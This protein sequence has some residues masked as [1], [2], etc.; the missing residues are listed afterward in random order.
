MLYSY[1]SL[2]FF[3]SFFFLQPDVFFVPHVWTLTYHYTRL[4]LLWEQTSIR[5]FHAPS[6]VLYATPVA[7]AGSGQTPPPA[8]AATSAS[9]AGAQQA[10]T[11]TGGGHDLK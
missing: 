2:T 5:L 9:A 6:A 11:H 3:S 1:F 4:D 7:A 8:P 10:L